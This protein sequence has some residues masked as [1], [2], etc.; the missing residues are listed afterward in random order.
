VFVTADGRPRRRPRWVGRVLGTLMGVWVAAVFAGA[1]GFL[2]MPPI[3]HLHSMS[4]QIVAPLGSAIA[5]S[6]RYH[7][8][9]RFAGHSRSR[10]SSEHD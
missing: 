5:K 1:L 4:R 2:Q 7:G 8:L 10:K 6:Q 9:V 3:G